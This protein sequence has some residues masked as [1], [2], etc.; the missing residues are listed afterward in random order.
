MKVFGMAGIYKL[1]CEDFLRNARTLKSLL[2]WL[3]ILV[4]TVLKM[5]RLGSSLILFV[6]WTFFFSQSS[7]LPAPNSNLE[8]GTTLDQLCQIHATLLNDPDIDTDQIRKLEED[9]L[10]VN[11]RIED[12]DKLNTNNADPWEAASKLLDESSSEDSII[13]DLNF[14]NL[15]AESLSESS[16]DNCTLNSSDNMEVFTSTLDDSKQSKKENVALG[17][18]I[19][20]VVAILVFIAAV[21]MGLI[22]FCVRKCF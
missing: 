19:A 7:S 13:P 12:C 14:D 15:P 18:V 2:E 22:F 11:L 17:G 21:F 9:A 1:T 4:W 3:R 20:G 5:A 10:K 6:L 16:C 8:G